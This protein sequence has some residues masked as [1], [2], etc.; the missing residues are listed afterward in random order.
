M[1]ASSQT[2]QIG[3]STYYA[4]SS[5]KQTNISGTSMAAPQVVGVGA[6][7][8]QLNPNY[9]P[10]Q[11]K[12]Q[13]EGDAKSVIYD[14]T[15]PSGY[16]VTNALFGSNNRMLFNKYGVEKDGTQKNGLVVRNAAINL[17]K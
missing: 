10:A 13:L 16:D 4:N 1:S 6:L 11:L 5:Y 9:T 3:G 8:L 2:N 15:N 7:H 17:R 12:T 14:N